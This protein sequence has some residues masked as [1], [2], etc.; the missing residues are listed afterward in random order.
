[1]YPINISNQVLDSVSTV[2]LDRNAFYL[3]FTVL[4]T[5]FPL[6]QTKKINLPKIF[7]QVAEK[8]C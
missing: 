4:L 5:Y 6:Y 8:F 3:G 1:M 2:L 7:L